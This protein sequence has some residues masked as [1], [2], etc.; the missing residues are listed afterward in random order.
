MENPKKMKWTDEQE[1]AINYR[2]GAAIVS[3]AAGSGKTA[4]LV[5]RVMRLILNEENRINAD[6][7]VITTFTQ[8]AA[9]ELKARLSAA[10]SKALSEKP[11]SVFLRE[12]SLRLNDASISTISSFCLNL[13]RRNSAMLEISPDFSILDESE[14]KLI[15]SKAVDAVIEEFCE[16]GD[17]EERERLYDWYGDEDDGAIAEIVAKMYRFSRNLISPRE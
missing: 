9:A 5:E 7:I 13:I 2:G 11:E 15:L 17:R 10:L 4:V 14:E 6:E 12:Q 3:A 16:K 1:Y 8:K